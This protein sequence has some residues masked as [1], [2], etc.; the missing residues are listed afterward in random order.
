MTSQIKHLSGEDVPKAWRPT[1][2]V[3]W[4]VELNGTVVGGPYATEEEARAVLEGKE[5]PRISQTPT[6]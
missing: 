5:E 6:P 1:W 2:A 3:C 4:V